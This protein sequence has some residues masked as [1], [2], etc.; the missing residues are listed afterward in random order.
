MNTKPLKLDGVEKAD[1]V[2]DW[3]GPTNR[4]GAVPDDISFHSIGNPHSEGYLTVRPISGVLAAFR[5]LTEQGLRLSIVSRIDPEP[6]FVEE[7]VRKWNT[8]YGIDKTIPPNRVHFCYEW[9]EKL[10]F[11]QLIRPRFVVD[12]R[13]AVLTHLVG[14]VPHLFLFRPGSQDPHLWFLV[15]THQVYWVDSWDEVFDVLTRVL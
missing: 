13:L 15:E 8:H 10:T 4:N 7:R 3:S 11:C 5:K 1:G 6:A 9:H 2:I 12:D 14:L